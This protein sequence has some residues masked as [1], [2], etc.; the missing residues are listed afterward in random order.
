M[1]RLIALPLVA[2]LALPGWLPLPRSVERWLH[3]AGERTR[4]AIRDV[5]RGRVGDAASALE[6]AS[7]LEPGDPLV[8]YNTGTGRL[9]NGKGDAEQPLESAARSLEGQ[10]DLAADAWYNLGTARLQ[11]HDPAGAVQALRQALRHDSHDQ[12]A[13][14]NLELALAR[15][16]KQRQSERDRSNKSSAG[17]SSQPSTS[18]Q[19]ESSEKKTDADAG[20]APAPREAKGKQSPLPQFKDQPD[21]SAEQAASI[22]EAVENLEREQRRADAERRI[23]RLP[24]GGKDW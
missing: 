7:R 13:K 2:A 24:N 5:E 3:N 11:K 10:P 18:K 9:M 23:R 1:H 12:N 17:K 6:S 8:Q 15:L 16:E 21:M 19:G 4:T 14:F 22:L 20:Q